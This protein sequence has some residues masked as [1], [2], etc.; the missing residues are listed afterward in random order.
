MPA[1][2]ESRHFR[3]N[4]PSIFMSQAEESKRELARRW[5]VDLP[6]TMWWASLTGMRTT[7]HP[8]PSPLLRVARRILID[9]GGIYDFHCSPSPPPRC[10]PFS[11]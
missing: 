7:L 2:N 10:V 5:S 1:G 6:V 9:L 4:A 3:R 8:S 11:S